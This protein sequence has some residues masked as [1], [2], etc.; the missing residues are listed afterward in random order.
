[1]IQATHLT[2]EFG[3]FTAVKN[4]SLDVPEGEVLA[5]LGPNGAG[6][7]TTVRMLGAILKPT[8]G[9]ARIAGYD[10]VTDAKA[11][12]RVIGLLTEF[13]GLYLRM[14]G[15]DYLAFFGELQG[16]PKPIIRQRSEELLKR[17]ELWE[18]RDKS[19]GTY[20]KGMKQKL[21]LVRAMLHDPLVLFLD[22]P[23]SAMDPHS[24]K[25]VRDSI[26]NLRQEKR[27]IV[28]CTHNLA[29]A[30]QLA[31]RIA[32]IRRGQIIAQGTPAELKQ[33]LLGDPLMEIRLAAPL[34]GLVSHLQERVNIVG[35]GQDWIRYTVPDPTQFNPTLLNELAHQDIPIITLSEVS[36]SLEE[37]YLRIVE[38]DQTEV[39]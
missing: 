30:E 28:L 22:E 17:F 26:A 25:L 18:A 3:E 27:T 10:T 35:H 4:V 29:E 16:V 37:V 36:R 2:K 15:L 7:T 38:A 13:P 39:K 24:A 8:Y 20:S 5:L 19:V 1:M 23:T 9:S 6:K 12:R 11:V 31:D 34:N 33:R 32:I 14:K 21:T